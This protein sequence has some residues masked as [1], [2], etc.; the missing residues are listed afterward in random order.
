MGNL[1][2]DGIVNIKTA[3]PIS[4][5]NMAFFIDIILPFITEWLDFLKKLRRIPTIKRANIITIL[6]AVQSNDVIF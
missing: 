2:I 4:L 3:K 6:D 5:M 1:I